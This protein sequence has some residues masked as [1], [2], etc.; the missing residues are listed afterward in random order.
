MLHH[1]LPT[2][3]MYVIG[4]RNGVVLC[5]VAGILTRSVYVAMLE[6][7][8]EAVASL[9][10]SGLLVNATASMPVASL[11]W[12]AEQAPLVWRKAIGDAQAP[13]MALI[14]NAYSL[15]WYATLFLRLS[16]AG[17]MRSAFGPTESLAAARWAQ[18]T[19]LLHRCWSA[20]TSASG[21]PPSPGPAERA[22][23]PSPADDRTPP[24]AAERR[25]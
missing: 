18:Q 13:P 21:S 3:D 22:S 10:G 5:D 15:Q 25:R 12:L 23:M 1:K 6:R 4:I 19:A 20:A 2:A 24:P 7:V 16:A 14:A 17:M 11:D 9:G 8:T